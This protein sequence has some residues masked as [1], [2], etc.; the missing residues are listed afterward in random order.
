MTVGRP[1]EGRDGS[2]V[3]FED[4]QARGGLKVVD[5]G[6]AFVCSHGETLGFVVEV[7]GRVA[8]GVARRG[9]GQG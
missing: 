3:P 8:V 5:D 2:F 1:R 9:G 7:D 4:V 6:R